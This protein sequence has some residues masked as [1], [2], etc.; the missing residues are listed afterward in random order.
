MGW[1]RRGA[2]GLPEAAEQQKHHGA[3][4]EEDLR[5]QARSVLAMACASATHPTT[6]SPV[7]TAVE[8]DEAAAEGRHPPHTSDAARSGSKATIRNR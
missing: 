8:A 2:S 5:A 1:S 3:S 6:S 7:Q 4:I